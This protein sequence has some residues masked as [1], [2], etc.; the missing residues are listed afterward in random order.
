[1]DCTTQ[2]LHTIVKGDTLYKLSQRY[3][4]TISDIL[5][6]N[7]RINPYNVQV[8]TR[9]IICPG[10]QGKPE[11][12]GK[13][14]NKNIS[15]AQLILS[16]RMRTAWSQHVFWTRL[17]IISILDGL[18]D[19]EA[20]QK[21][22]L[23]N[24]HDIAK[25]FVPYYGQGTANQIEAL[26][27]QHLVLGESLIRATKAND[28][29][30]MDKNNQL[31]HANADEIAHAL[32]LLNPSFDEKQLQNM[33]YTHLNLTKSEVAARL[34]RDFTADI[35][36]FDKIEAEALE[37]ADYFTNGIVGQFPKAF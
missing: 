20:T 35:N 9:L 16:N 10:F 26:I 2:I 31:W 6:R 4:T 11:N 36:A 32:A 29:E 12:E 25:L 21:R 30:Q 18:A 34:A 22:L 33:M 3:N 7:P 8:G 1:M 37:M 28:T 17:L 14:D 19:A 24:P 5:A 15:Q 23:Q 27:T 13:K